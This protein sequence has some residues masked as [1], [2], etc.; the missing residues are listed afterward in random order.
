MV[1]LAQ[2]H[3]KRPGFQHTEGPDGQ[4]ASRKSVFFLLPPKLLKPRESVGLKYAFPTLEEK[5]GEARWESQKAKTTS[6]VFPPSKAGGQA[7]PSGRG[8]KSWKI[9]V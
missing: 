3:G 5:F 8:L 1:T 2:V 7:S 4:Y 9:L 6:P